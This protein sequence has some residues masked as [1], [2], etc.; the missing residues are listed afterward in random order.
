M[1]RGGTVCVRDRLDRRLSDPCSISTVLESA[2][3][4]FS[5]PRREQGRW[6]CYSPRHSTS[7]CPTVAD[8]KT[9]FIHHIDGLICLALSLELYLVSPLKLD[10]LVEI[11]HKDQFDGRS[12][13]ASCHLD[14]A[15]GF[16]AR[17]LLLSSSVYPLCILSIVTSVLHN[18]VPSQHSPAATSARLGYFL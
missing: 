13:A 4:C 7:S 5:S 12:G 16:P 8:F 6:P 10:V 17:V 11:L 18:F 9:V 14:R 15:A 1:T 3:A 2:I